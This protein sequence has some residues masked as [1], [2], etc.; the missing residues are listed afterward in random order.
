MVDMIVIRWAIKVALRAYYG[1][2][3]G[4]YS[5]SNPCNNKYPAYFR[6]YQ[7]ATPSLPPIGI[8]I[9]VWDVE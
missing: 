3:A 1:I 5:T 9:L 7:W 2:L 8:G 6:Y 4:M